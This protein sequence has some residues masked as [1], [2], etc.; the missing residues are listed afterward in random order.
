V[1]VVGRAANG[2]WQ[3]VVLSNSGHN[4]WSGRTVWFND[5][6]FNFMTRV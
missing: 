4:G 6:A 3:A 5:A 2:R 1:R